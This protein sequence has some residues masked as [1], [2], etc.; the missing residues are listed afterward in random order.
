MN[1]AFKVN[2]KAEAHSL[3]NHPSLPVRHHGQCAVA[4][5]PLQLIPPSD[6]GNASWG[7]LPDPHQAGAL[8]S[9]ALWSCWAMRRRSASLAR[10]FN[11]SCTSYTNCC[12]DISWLGPLSFLQEGKVEM[13]FSHR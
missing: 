13:I 10:G 4:T 11:W 1:C 8:T 7:L 2:R 6:A 9:P 5:L 12:S 3:G